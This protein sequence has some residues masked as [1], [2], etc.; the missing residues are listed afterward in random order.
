V[1]KNLKKIEKQD[2]S[3][4]PTRRVVV[5][6]ELG[7][8]ELSSVPGGGIQHLRPWIWFPDVGA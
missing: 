6:R 2:P 1:K 3:T 7:N 8:D 4:K 5:L